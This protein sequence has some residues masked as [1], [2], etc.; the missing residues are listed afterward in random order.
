MSISEI[1]ELPPEVK[2]I[3]F[4]S[5]ISRAN[6]EIVD[7]FFLNRDQL[8]FLLGLEED[9]FLKKI[10]LLDLPNELED[11]E[12]AEHYDLRVIALEIA[13][14]ILWPLQDFLETVDRLILRLG[15]KV[16]KIQHLRKETL[17]RKLLPTNITGRVRKLMEDYDDFRSSRLTSKKIID[18]YERHVAPT[19]D[20]WLQDYVHFAGAGYHNSLKRAE[21]LAKSSNITSLSQVEK[22]SLR[23][24]L[25]S[26][27]DD[28][29]VDVENAGSLLKITSA[30]KPDKSSPQ[31][32]ADINE[33]LNNLHRQYL[34]ID[35]KILPPDFILS[36]VNNDAIKIR[37]VLWQAVG[38]QDKYKAVSCLKVLIEKK[39]L[40]LMLRE[41][42]RFRGILKRFI[43]IRYG[44]NIN[45]WFDNNSD[46]LLTRRLFLEVL[47]VER[48]SFSEQEAALLAFYLINTVSDSGQV[49]YLDEAD[50]QLKWREVQLIKNQL[51]WV[52]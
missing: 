45:S 15:G 13:Y 7:K 16:P 8:N 41:D 4:S 49:V 1:Q 2:D 44:R 39:S 33:I 38:V 20:H 9:L 42:N 35:Q 32:K 3:I 22:E 48:L 21:Y 10:D 25:I 6:K 30:T 26:Y 17:Q 12:R 14:R 37:D 23:H 19:V 27:D 52:A 5:D 43:N 40:D 47:L 11:M 50:G 51:S 24:F 31:D 18:K 28:I 36:E 34:E 29:D 46:K